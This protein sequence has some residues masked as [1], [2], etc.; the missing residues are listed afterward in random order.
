M[1]YNKTISSLFH[2]YDQKKTYIYNSNL[3]LTTC[4][5]AKNKAVASSCNVELRT[6]FVLLHAGYAYDRP[7]NKIMYICIVFAQFS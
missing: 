6:E 7:S 2:R 5:Q 1:K 3:Q 4:T